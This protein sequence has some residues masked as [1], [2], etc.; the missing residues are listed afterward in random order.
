MVRLTIYQISFLVVFGYIGI[1]MQAINLWQRIQ[2]QRFNVLE[3]ALDVLLD[4]RRII[5]IALR[6]LV[7]GIGHHFD[8]DK[9][10]Q[11]G[12]EQTHIFVVSD[13]AAIIAFAKQILQRL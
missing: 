6:K 7:I 9:F 3:I 2:W 10:G 13:T 5:E 8:I 1:I 12:H 11:N 4:R